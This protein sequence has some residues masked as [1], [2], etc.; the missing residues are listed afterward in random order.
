[1]YKYTFIGAGVDLFEGD[2]VLTD[3]QKDIIEH[4]NEMSEQEASDQAFK[5]RLTSRWPRG[6]VPFVLDKS[7]S[8][9]IE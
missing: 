7:L 5:R 1:M 8:Q 3:K 6:V 2:I 9:F 4:T